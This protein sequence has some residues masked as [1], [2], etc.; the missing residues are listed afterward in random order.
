M[1]T[2]VPLILHTLQGHMTTSVPHS[3][4]L[5]R[6]H[7]TTTSVPHSTHL[8]MSHMTTSILLILHTLQGHITTNV[9][10]STHLTR[11]HDNNKRPSFYTLQCHTTTTSVLSRGLITLLT[12]ALSSRRF[13]SLRDFKTTSSSSSGLVVRLVSTTT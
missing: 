3:T 11:S 12:T 6:S 9:P 8:T 7:M 5:I 10:H 4:H 13:L 1:T 2:S